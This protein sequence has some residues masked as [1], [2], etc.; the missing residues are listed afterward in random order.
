MAVHIRAL[1][2]GELTTFIKCQWEFYKNDPNWVPPLIME[3]RKLLDTKRNPFFHHSK[4]QL[5][6]AE[7]DG[8]IVGRI[9]AIT[10]DNHNIEHNDNIGFFGFFECI[11]D[12]SV[13]RA[14]LDAAESWL[15]AEGK[16]AIRGPVNPSMND[17]IGILVEGFD[18]PP[19]IMMTYNPPYYD[20]LIQGAGY[21]KVRDV[22]AFL[23]EHKNFKT[24]RMKRTFDVLIKRMQLSWRSIN[25][26]DK[27][28]FHKDVE[29]LKNIYNKTWQPN[30]GFVKMTDAEF[31][32]LAADL[33]QVADPRLALLFYS[34]GEICGCVLAL[35]DINQTLIHNKG[36]G[37]LGG[38]W[39][40]FTKRNK[41]TLCRIIILGVLPEFQGK[42]I[43]AVMYSIIGD[44]A[45]NRGMSHGEASWILEDNEMMMRGL[46]HTMNARRYRTYRLYE[47]PIIANN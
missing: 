26:K 27:A 12:P 47:K 31:D 15:R 45:G 2:P 22:F 17:E 24:D 4:I 36:G 40:L 28:E 10:N 13:A 14:L 29:T 3:R 9:A 23:L 16:T 37:I 1:A 42:G 6:V 34:Q 41:I 21:P 11:N 43:D 38:L 44:A 33:K 46:T 20:A 32:F 30:W 35:P 25:L 18:G 7:Q 5:F 19:V 39:H 8:R